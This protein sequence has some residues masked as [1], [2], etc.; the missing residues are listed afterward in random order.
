M[1]FKLIA[2]FCTLFFVGT[3]LSA[4]MEG[5]GG[6]N[7]TY[8]TND[9]SAVSTTIEVPST[10]SW[11]HSDI[12]IIGNEKIRYTS[13]GDT[14]FNVPATDGRGYDGTSASAH[15]VGSYVM[16][17]DTNVVNSILGF[18]IASTGTT[19]GSVSIPLVLWNF[20]FTSV[21]RLAMWDYSWLTP[22]MLL[23]KVAFALP[24][25]AFI[26]YI[27]YMIA[28]ALGGVMQSILR[29]F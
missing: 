4:I 17:K 16:S 18:N 15:E 22:D 21:P 9:E 1:S 19:V 20:I 25:S 27:T 13:K 5:G 2:A 6:F 3:V 14:R 11:L 12:I 28:M 10:D 29:L 7:T 24:T 26:I 8:L 23:L